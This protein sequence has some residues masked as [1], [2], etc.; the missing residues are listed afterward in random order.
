MTRLSLLLIFQLALFSCNQAQQQTME[1]EY[2]NVGSIK[3]DLSLDEPSF[4]VCDEQRI[5]EYYNFQKGFQF[6][7][8]K[9]TLIN[10]FKTNY[11]VQ[12]N[13]TGYFT[14]R[15]VVNC[16]GETGRFRTEAMNFSYQPVEMNEETTRQLLKLC[17]EVK[18]WGIGVYQDKERDYYQYLTFKIEKGQL[19]EILP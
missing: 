1:K 17:K 19:T 12:A 4:T 6:E 16:R 9:V 18:G 3:S 11:K 13:D 7:G 14:V 8:E 10:Y 15:F 5:F 2:V